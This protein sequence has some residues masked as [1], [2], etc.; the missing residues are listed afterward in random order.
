MYMRSVNNNH[1]KTSRIFSAKIQPTVPNIYWKVEKPKK[2]YI[3][4]V[5]QATSFI[6]VIKV[7]Q[8]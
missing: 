4:E 7:G 1:K 8:N 5:F 2:G 6:S 3:T